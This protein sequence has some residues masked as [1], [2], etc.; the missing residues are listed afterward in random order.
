V[1]GVPVA[2]LALIA[3]GWALALAA[4]LSGEGAGLHHD[5]LIGDGT[6]LWL[7]AILAVAAWQ[8]MTAAMMLPSSLPMVRLFAVTSRLQRR[9]RRV[10]TAFLGGYFAVWT[11]FALAAFLGDAA[12]HAAVDRWTWLAAHDNLIGAAVLATAGA[13]QFTALKDRCLTQCRHPGAYLISHYRRGARGALSVGAGHGLYC[14]GCCWAL[15]LVMFAVGVA[16]L[17][18][19]G[20]LTALMVYEK[21]ARAGVRAVSP[22][23][24]VL[25][26]WAALAAAGVS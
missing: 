5:A 2:V 14:L 10:V 8:T 13:F 25:L 26:G 23:G 24:V 6:S 22:A 7:S 11:A 9:R 18:W 1:G 16:S 4:E 21:T 3:G 17:F 19:M 12:M 20:L 15:M